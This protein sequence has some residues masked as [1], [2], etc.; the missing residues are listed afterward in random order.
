M[1]AD[2]RKEFDSVLKKFD[3]FFKVRKNVIFER[4]RF[5]R[6]SQHEGETAEKYIME[7]YRLSENCDYG[8]MRDD[9]IRDRLVVGIG[10]ASLSQQLQLDADLNL[11]KAKQKIRQRE[12]VSEQQRE[13]KGASL[14][15]TSLETVRFR[16]LRERCQPR[17]EAN[18]TL[19][20]HRPSAGAA[21]C[22]NTLEANAQQKMLYAIAA[23]RRVTTAPSASA[24][25]RLKS[26]LLRVRTQHS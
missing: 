18:R 13:L 7:L 17:G 2:E 21:E 22:L 9:M 6:R 23:K 5:N 12:A 1:T 16:N 24:S 3:D 20:T 11:E 4:A 25:K 14:E 8:E 10:D 19:R 26:R 15:H